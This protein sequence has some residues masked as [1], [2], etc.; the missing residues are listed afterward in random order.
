MLVYTAAHG[1]IPL[2]VKVYQQYFPF[3]CGQG[4]RQVD[5][6]GCF[7]DAALL[8][9]HREHNTHQVF[10]LNLSSTRQRSASS[11]GTEIGITWCTFNFE[12]GPGSG[13]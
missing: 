1:G 10:F 9:R 11:K 13:S 4:C 5:A 8:V 12:P 3:H 6:G 2:W 7:T